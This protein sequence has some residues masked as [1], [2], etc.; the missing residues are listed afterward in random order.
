MTHENT[1]RTIDAPPSSSDSWPTLPIIHGTS[2]ASVD[3][4]E[5]IEVVGPQAENLDLVDLTTA[6]PPESQVSR[7]V[8]RPVTRGWGRLHY[9]WTALQ[10]AAR[11]PWTLYRARQGA[12]MPPRL[13]THTVTFGCNARCVMCDSWQLSTTGDLSLEEIEHIYRQLP[14][15][16][17]VRLTGGEPFVRTDLLEIYHAASR[18]LKPLFVHISSNG[19]LSQRIVNFCQERDRTV[20]LELAI[21]IDGVDDYHNEIRG[22]RSA[23]RSAWKTLEALAPRRKELNLHLTVNQTV[24]NDQGLQQY[25]LLQERLKSMNIEHHLIVAYA[26]SATYSLDRDRRIDQTEFATFSELTPA[27][28]AEVLADAEQSASHLPWFRR[29]LR[30]NY[31]RG[32]ADRIL[33]NRSSRPKA[34]QALHA[35]LRLFPNGDVPVCQF[36]SQAVGNLR[37]QSFAEVWASAT[38]A[39]QRRWVRACAG[40]WAECEVAPNTIYTLDFHRSANA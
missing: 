17:A 18:H 20:P 2:D 22:S 7:T 36:N 9:G 14:P 39:D 24:V 29:R 16:D 38:A 6:E 31:L 23:F 8:K 26:E 5:A 3:A 15:L 21:S 27:K 32:V 33:H 19:F 35:H 30:L 37:H 4:P 13:L 11:F 1:T 25:K 40:C 28:V 34:C 12:V 10:R